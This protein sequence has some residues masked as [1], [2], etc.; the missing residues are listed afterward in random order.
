MTETSV[1]LVWSAQLVQIETFEQ[2]VLNDPSMQLVGT[3]TS[4]RSTLKL[5]T[6]IGCHGV[7]LDIFTLRL[8]TQIG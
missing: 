8:L 3:E 7:L 2:L 1:Q 6:T 4:A 5:V